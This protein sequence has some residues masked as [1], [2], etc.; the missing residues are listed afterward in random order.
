MSMRPAFVM[1][2]HLN[3]YAVDDLTYMFVCVLCNN[4]LCNNYPE[5][6]GCSSISDW[7]LIITADFRCWHCLFLLFCCT[8]SALTILRWEGYVACK[9]PGIKLLIILIDREKNFINLLFY[10]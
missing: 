10:C 6:I 2:L 4:Y 8:F 7:C 9:R 3:A 1:L 5:V